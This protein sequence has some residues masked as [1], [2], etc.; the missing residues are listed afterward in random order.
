MVLL[1]L[2]E[3]FLY[4]G[5]ASS[6]EKITVALAFLAIVFAFFS[7]MARFGDR[8]LVEV[9]FNRIKGCVE[10]NEKP[11]LKALIKMKAKNQKFDLEEIYIQDP[12]IFKR[13]KLLERLYEK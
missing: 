3:I 11:L 1:V 5:N 2:I 9:N 6:S 7:L 12:S 10:E 4:F 13:E 8:N